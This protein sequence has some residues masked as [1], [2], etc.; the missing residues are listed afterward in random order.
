MEKNELS[1]ESQDMTDS[2]LRN[3]QKISKNKSRNLSKTEEHD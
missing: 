2:N 3:I 1:L